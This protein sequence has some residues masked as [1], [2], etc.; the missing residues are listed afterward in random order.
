V[1]A[2]DTWWLLPWAGYAPVQAQR[3]HWCAKGD[4]GAGIGGEES[5][6]S[7]ALPRGKERKAEL[8]TGMGPLGL[9]LF[10]QPKQ[11]AWL[12]AHCSMP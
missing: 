9:R 12:Y 5:R 10:V 1:R 7:E 2:G 6:G 11:W 4:R 3:V 8:A